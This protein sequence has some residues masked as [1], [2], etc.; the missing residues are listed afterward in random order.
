MMRVGTV[1]LISAFLSSCGTLPD[2]PLPRDGVDK[3]AAYP[4]FVP[5]ERVVLEN[6]TAQ[7]DNEETEEALEARVAGLRA[8]AAQ[9]RKAQT[10]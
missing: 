1:L 9:L 4:D 6:A 2:V 5:L 8:R 7:S 10:E 3:D